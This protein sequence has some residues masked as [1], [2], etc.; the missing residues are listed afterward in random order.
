MAFTLVE[1]LVVVAII[2]IL[3]AILFPVF[4]RARENARRISCLSNA[5]QIG[6][7][8]FLYKEDYDGVFPPSAYISS[9]ANRVIWADLIQPHV[10]NVQ[11]FRC[12]SDSVSARIS[13]GVNNRAFADV[14]NFPPILGAPSLG[15]LR[16]QNLAERILGVE[17]GQNDDFSAPIADSWKVVLPSET[18]NFPG[19]ARPDARH[20]ERAKL[21]SLSSPLTR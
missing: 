14:E 11:I 20:F 8:V 7:G 9:D 16:Y 6:F 15:A 21:T 17:S 12:P 1:I 4:G 2:G 5:R 3:A 13:Y 19:D 10:K 18:L